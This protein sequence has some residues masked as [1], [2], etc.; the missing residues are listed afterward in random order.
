MGSSN[1]SRSRMGSIKPLGIHLFECIR[2]GPLSLRS[3][4]ALVLV[5]TFLSYASYHATRKTTSIVKSVLDPKT[6]NLGLLHWPSHL[7]LQDLKGA[8]NNT[9]LQSGW[10]LTLS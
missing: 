7:Y 2:G 1:E 3:C 5:L 6:S 8:A 4:Q 9:A 10:A